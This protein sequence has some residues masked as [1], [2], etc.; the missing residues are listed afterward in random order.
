MISLRGKT[1][2]V[3]GAS[4]GLGRLIALGLAEQGCNLVVHASTTQNLEQVIQQTRAF[5]VTVDGVAADLADPLQVSAMLDLLEAKF[6]PIDVV[7]NN[8]GL[9]V[10]YRKD[11]WA[12]PS[13]DFITSFQVN[14]IAAT[15]ICYRLIPPMIERHF[16]RV[17][18]VT[19]GIQDEPEQ[20]GYS[21]SKA[22]LN[23]VTRDL[24]SHLEGS[25]VLINLADPGWCRT[26][27]GG[28]RAPFA[29]D[30]ALPGMLVG[31]FVSDGRSGRTFRAQNYRDLSLTQAVISAELRHFGPKIPTP[32]ARPTAEEISPR[33]NLS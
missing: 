16:G 6:Q 19:S 21:A 17:V 29:P 5:D 30:S 15:M 33:S 31:A 28:P 11:F 2:L 25:N 3:T 4:R 10:A 27:L 24:G 18:N 9:Q 23:K 22:A 7:F 14:C 8:A 13:E 12:T 26:D 32:S 20:A 1:A